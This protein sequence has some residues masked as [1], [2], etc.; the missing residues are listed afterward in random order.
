M[1]GH[2]TSANSVDEALV[3]YVKT[4]MERAA[5]ILPFKGQTVD[6]IIGHIF[7]GR[8]TEPFFVYLKISE[9]VFM[10][11]FLDNPTLLK[12]SLEQIGLFD[13]VSELYAAVT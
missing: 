2:R 8:L 5:Q 12:S 3:F 13:A 11:D 10:L 1:P 7:K 6:K 4:L 9:I